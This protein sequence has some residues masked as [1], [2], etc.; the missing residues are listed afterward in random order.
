[1]GEWIYEAISI[2]SSMTALTAYSLLGA[3]SYAYEFSAFFFGRGGGGP[4]TNW[5]GMYRD[6]KKI[7]RVPTRDP[8]ILRL[9]D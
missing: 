4:H 5:R 3:V 2:E 1:M 6:D 9:R 7:T 8:K